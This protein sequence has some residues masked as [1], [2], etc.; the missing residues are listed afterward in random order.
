MPD[1]KFPDTSQAGVCGDMKDVQSIARESTSAV[2]MA[3]STTTLTSIQI[4][5]YMRRGAWKDR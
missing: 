1:S 3:V 4:D 2:K 5:P